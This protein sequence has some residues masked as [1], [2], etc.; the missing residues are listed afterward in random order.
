M[1]QRSRHAAEL[2]ALAPTTRYDLGDQPMSHK[3]QRLLN[4]IFQDP[5]AGNIHWREIESL[6]NHLGASIEPGHGARL[7]VILNGVEG[8]LHRP[9]H[10][11]AFSKQDIRH[12]REYLVTAGVSAPP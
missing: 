7:K 3:H 8:T 9:H 2:L 6:L 10:G 11:G 4:A 12:L 1:K 5:I